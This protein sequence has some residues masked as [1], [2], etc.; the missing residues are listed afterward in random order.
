MINLYLADE[1]LFLMDDQ[2]RIWSY[3]QNSFSKVGR[4]NEDELLDLIEFDFNNI[5][6]TQFSAFYLFYFYLFY[7]YY[8]IYFYIFLFLFLFLF[9]FF[10]FFYYF[11]FLF[12]FILFFIILHFLFFK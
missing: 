8:L 10:I 4:S 11:I 12:Y 6:I 9:L 3:G 5:Q 1:G 2:K 7:F